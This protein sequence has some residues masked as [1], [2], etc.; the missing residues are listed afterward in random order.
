M[1]IKTL[2]LSILMIWTLSISAQQKSELTIGYG[3]LTSNDVIDVFSD[4]LSPLNIIN[5]VNSTNEKYTG[6]FILGYRYALTDR[7]AL[8][9]DVIFER[10]TK[11][12]VGSNDAKIGEQEDDTYSF[13]AK[14]DYSFVSK[15]KLRLYSGLGAGYSFAN[16]EY[17]GTGDNS[18]NDNRTGAFAFQVTAIG[19]RVGGDFAVKAELGFGA[20]GI[21]NVGITHRF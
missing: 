10:I 15:N 11:D 4:I 20:A 21:A 7:L 17:T 12:I 14:I 9:G 16:Q 8:G 1:K 18:S 13:L 2:L 5:I 19:L 6:A 3:T